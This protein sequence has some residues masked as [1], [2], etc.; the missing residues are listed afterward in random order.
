M[1]VLI[2]PEVVIN[3]A[4][5]AKKDKT[6]S[7]LENNAL[8]TF[9]NILYQKIT[10]E[11]ESG[12]CYK[13]VYFQMDEADVEEFCD[14]DDQFIQGIDR[15]YCTREVQ[16]ETVAKVNSIYTPEVRTMLKNARDTF[17]QL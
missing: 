6:Q 4:F 11:N 8:R 9:C 1:C 10:S 3:N 12:I 2:S 13:Y 17:S 14:I 15:V 5:F 16:E 7:F